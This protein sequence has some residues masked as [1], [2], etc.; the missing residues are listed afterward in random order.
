MVDSIGST[1]LCKTIDQIESMRA[2]S[3]TVVFN[4]FTM[5]SRDKKR[6]RLSSRRAPCVLFSTEDMNSGVPSSV[7]KPSVVNTSLDE[8]SMFAFVYGTS[9]A[10][11]RAVGRQRRTDSPEGCVASL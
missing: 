4:I 10:A 1:V 9:T 8:A 6:E 11:G 7:S 5:F 3:T 2:L